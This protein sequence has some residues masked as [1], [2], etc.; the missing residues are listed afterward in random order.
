MRQQQEFSMALDTLTE[1]FFTKTQAAEILGKS[2]PTLDRW[3]RLGKGPKR[4]HIGK[5]VLYRKDT[6]RAWV[7]DQQDPM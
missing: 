5:T 2:I 7:R 4:T 6:L 1:D 3:H